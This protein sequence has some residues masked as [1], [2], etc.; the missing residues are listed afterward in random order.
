M[1]VVGALVGEVVGAFV[2]E[3]V[4]A[5]VG[6]VGGA[7][8][9]EVVKAFVGE[10]VGAFVGEVV[11]TFVGEAVL[12]VGA[13]VGE[14]VG[15]VVISLQTAPAPPYNGWVMLA[16]ADQLDP[17]NFS[18]VALAVVPAVPLTAYKK[19]SNVRAT[20]AKRLSLRL[21]TALHVLVPPS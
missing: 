3:V 2:G 6:E 8:V 12:V 16:A 1:L 10:V 14:V 18:T 19:P 5:F 13:S 4:G 20:A 9:G 11:G 15:F 7:F 21:V 17:S